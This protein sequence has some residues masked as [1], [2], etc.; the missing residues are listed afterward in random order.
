MEDEL[1][2]RYLSGEASAEEEGQLLAWRAVRPEN[3]RHFL[4][5]KKLF[6]LSNKYYSQQN[7]TRT[8]INLDKE[9]DHFVN[10]IDKKNAPVR[11][12]TPDHS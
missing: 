6:E 7:G 8:D 1:I 9:W 12:L 2:I 10:Q 4:T 11:T 3:E 5:T